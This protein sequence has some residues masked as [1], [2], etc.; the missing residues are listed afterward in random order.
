M[1]PQCCLCQGCK[2]SQNKNQMLVVFKGIHADKTVVRGGCWWCGCSAWTDDL[3]LL[4]QLLLYLSPESG[5]TRMELSWIGQRRQGTLAWHCI[6]W[7]AVSFG[8]VMAF[9][10]FF[11]WQWAKIVRNK[12]K[13][14]IWYYVIPYV[15][16]YTIH[17]N[18]VAFSFMYVKCV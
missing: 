17:S 6:D 2:P 9:F 12:F 1:N 8:S 10:Y 13:L 11:F 4:C 7:L 14:S 5:W 3:G 16:P 15:V 18:I